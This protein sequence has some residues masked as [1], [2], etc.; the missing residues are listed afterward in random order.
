MPGTVAA[1]TLQH[2]ATSAVMPG[3]RFRLRREDQLDA[4]HGALG[5]ALIRFTAFT[6][7]YDPTIRQ[8]R[9]SRQNQAPQD[10]VSA[11]EP[12]RGWR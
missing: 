6:A 8:T 9:P 12:L 7:S 2:D 10:A 3:W 5:F 11:S 1:W 4:A